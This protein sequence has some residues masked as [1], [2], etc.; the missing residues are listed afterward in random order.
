MRILFQYFII[1][2]ALIS[3]AQGLQALYNDTAIGSNIDVNAH[4]AGGQMNIQLDTTMGRDALL[5]GGNVNNAGT[6]S[7]NLTDR[8][9]S[10]QRT[11]ANRTLP[12]LERPWRD[13]ASLAFW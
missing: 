1:A 6:I 7:G 2:L 9:G 11:D 12:P 13:S 5:S 4:L 3:G 8:A 10:V